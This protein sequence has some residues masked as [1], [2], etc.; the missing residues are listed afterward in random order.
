MQTEDTSNKWRIFRKGVEKE[1]YTP[2]H[3]PEDFLPD[4]KLY[5]PEE[6]LAKELGIWTR[7][8]DTEVRKKGRSM[9]SVLKGAISKPGSKSRS[10]IVDGAQQQ[11]LDRLEPIVNKLIEKAVEGDSLAMKMAL[12]R[13]LPTIKQ[14]DENTQKSKGGVTINITG[15]EKLQ[16]A[17]TIEGKL[18]NSNEEEIQNGA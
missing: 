10:A 11:I 12:D 5:S 6:K 14:R 1:N 3:K 8:N 17:E 2:F 4:N 15:T 7:W 9:S 13:V 18:V 16:M